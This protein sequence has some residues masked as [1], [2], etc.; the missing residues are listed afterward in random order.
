VGAAIYD[1]AKTPQSS[2][3]QITRIL[4]KLYV[5]FNAK[6]LFL[7]LDFLTRP[8][9]LIEFVLAIKRPRPITVVLSPLRG[10]IEKFELE[11]EIQKRSSL[12]PT[13]KIDRLLELGI[14][15]KDL[16]LRSGEVLGFQLLAKL[17][18]KP[19]EEFPRMNLIELEVPSQEFDLI[20]WSV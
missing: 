16:N 4:D 9:P 20:E 6:T 15:F 18:G 5:G 2:M 14:S 7:R 10:V 13:Y 17:N 8:D 11:G 12:Q 19:L 3:H 1:I